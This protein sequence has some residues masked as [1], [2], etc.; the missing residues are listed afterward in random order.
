MI[1]VIAKF[2][3]LPL[4]GPAGLKLNVRLS[5]LECSVMSSYRVRVKS[6]IA[7]LAGVQLERTSIDYVDADEGDI[8]VFVV[9]GESRACVGRVHL[10]QSNLPE[11][12]RERLRGDVIDA[13]DAA[14]QSAVFDAIGKLHEQEISKWQAGTQAVVGSVGGVSLSHADGR[15]SAGSPGLR[16]W[17]SPGRVVF[18]SVMLVAAA[19]A[20]Y[21]I[22]AKTRPPEDPIASALMGPD[23]QKRMNAMISSALK[24]PS[25]DGGI[26]QGQ[27]VTLDTLKAMGLDPGKANT[28]CLVG[29]KP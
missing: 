21:G 12:S 29:V 2:D 6:R 16:R 9:G 14:Y 20:G 11:D 7:T 8:D 1:S 26:L 5:S 24:Q 22:Y 10:D 25:G 28:G 15:D 3:I 27:S 18:A 4:L 17:L 23:A 19:M 13:L